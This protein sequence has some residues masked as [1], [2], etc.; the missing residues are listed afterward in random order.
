MSYS[1]RHLF[2]AKVDISSTGDVAWFSSPN[3]IEI[4]RFFVSLIDATTGV[5][6]VVVDK[7]DSAGSRG[8]AD[9]ATVTVDTG[10]A[11]GH[12]GYETASPAKVL[13]PGEIAVFE[14]TDA[15]DA[16]AVVG[17]EY[18]INDIAMSDVT[19]AEAE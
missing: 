4:H 8:S 1:D 19:N 15:A 7:I 5:G 2:T 13:N 17:F 11:A 9:L 12:V 10:E 16:L 6:E 3:R 14:V 18:S